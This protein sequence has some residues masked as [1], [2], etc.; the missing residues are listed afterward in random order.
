M[1]SAISNS[2]FSNIVSN[3]NRNR[4]KKTPVVFDDVEMTNEVMTI[5]QAEL[6]LSKSGPNGS[7]YFQDNSCKRQRTTSSDVCEYESA[8]AGKSDKNDV[9]LMIDLGWI[10]NEQEAS[11][12]MEEQAKSL[13]D[14]GID[15]NRDSNGQKQKNS[16]TDADQT[17]NK[18]SNKRDKRIGKQQNITPFNYSNVG[19]IGV[20]GSSGVENPFFAGA[21]VSG[22]PSQSSNNNKEKKKQVRQNPRKGGKKPLPTGGAQSS[23][24]YR[25]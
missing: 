2:T 18:H 3:R 17:S 8:N 10:E 25:K 12:M 6:L 15:S 16:S 13:I 5:E 19:S 23:F 14:N 24:V 4:T 11:V 20:G 1:S 9:K 7:D 21:A 22:I